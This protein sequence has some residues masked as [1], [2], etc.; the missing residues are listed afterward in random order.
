MHRH[1]QF[2]ASLTL[3]VVL[4][5][6]AGMT[7]VAAGKVVFSDPPPSFGTAFASVVATYGFGFG[8]PWVAYAFLAALALALLGFWRLHWVAY[9]VSFTLLLGLALFSLN[10]V[11]AF[12]A[13]VLGRS[14]RLFFAMHPDHWR[15]VPEW[16]QFIASGFLAYAVFGSAVSAYA[17]VTRLAAARPTPTSPPA[18]RQVFV[19]DAA[20]LEQAAATLIG[21][22]TFAE[23]LVAAYAAK[24]I[25]AYPTSL[26]AVPLA[27]LRDQLPS[28][29][30][31]ALDDLPAAAAV[32]YWSNGSGF[33]LYAT[34]PIA[35]VH[36]K[37]LAVEPLPDTVLV[38]TDSDPTDDLDF[39]GLPD[40]TEARWRTSPVLAD[41][42]G[43]SYP[44]GVEVA[45]GFSPVFPAERRN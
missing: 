3:A 44:D 13:Y 21:V 27:S 19:P 30:A 12:S 31:E 28:S 11:A 7:T 14:W 45:N 6:A 38:R 23:V 42:D 4:A 37:R 43:D 39:D 2:S 20:K 5:F 32:G 16:R 33:A 35:F 1:R 15:G 10:I 36:P 18:V 41:T 22:R 29:A 34:L 17:P 8:E 24:N 25:T 40:G 26:Q 9:V